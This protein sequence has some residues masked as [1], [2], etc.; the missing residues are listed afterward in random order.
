MERA[1]PV[2]PGDDVKIAK[3]FYVDRLGFRVTFE[4]T[5]DG[6]NGMLGLERGAL[7][8]TIDCPMT[9]HGRNVC[10]VL[11]VE[12]AQSA[13]LRLSIRTRTPADRE[14]LEMLLGYEHEHAQRHLRELDAGHAVVVVQTTDDAMAERVGKVMAE[15]GGRFVNRYTRWAAVSVVP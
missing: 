13:I 6:T 12:I 15:H 2:L 3:E 14:M 11:E 10:A 9:G 1:V 4:A 5:E 8:L 7:C